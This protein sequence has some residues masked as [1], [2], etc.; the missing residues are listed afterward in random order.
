MTQNNELAAMINGRQGNLV[1]LLPDERTFRT[2]PHD[3][4]MVYKWYKPDLDVREWGSIRTTRVWDL[5]GLEDKVGHVYD[6]PG[7]YRMHMSVPA[8]FAGKTILLHFSGRFGKVLVWVNG[9]FAAYRSYPKQRWV[10]TPDRVLR[11]QHQQ[12]GQGARE[13]SPCRSSGQRP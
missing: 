2:D 5:Q 12:F 13:Q 11:H 7:W 9:R 1:A 4:G 6:G 8:C 3:E 10:E